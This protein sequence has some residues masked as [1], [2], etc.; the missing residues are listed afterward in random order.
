MQPGT[1]S[2]EPDLSS[3]VEYAPLPQSL[4]AWEHSSSGFPLPA[5]WDKRQQEQHQG[6]VA[7]HTHWE[8]HSSAL[9]N[10]TKAIGQLVELSVHH[11]RPW[12]SVSGFAHLVVSE[13]SLQS[14]LQVL[15]ISV[16]VPRHVAADLEHKSRWNKGK[17]VI[18][19]H[20]GWQAC[21]S[22]ASA[23]LVYAHPVPAMLSSQKIPPA[24]GC[25][26]ASEGLG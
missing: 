24:L 12:I 19:P 20:L 4:S 14:L 8:L 7:Q 25:T 1:L 11:K 21:L 23:V 17:A 9:W 3:L 5:R 26:Y 10:A 15:L 13:D 2:A 22:L 6:I 16:P 18:E